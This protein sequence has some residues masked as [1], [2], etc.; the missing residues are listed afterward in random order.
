MSVNGRGIKVF[1]CNSNLEVAKSIAKGIG[2]QLGKCKISTFS[3]GEISISI[4]E[5]VR[6]ADVFI[7]QSTN[8]PVND[9]I[10]ELALMCDACKRSSATSVT[11][12]MPY[13]G[14]ARQDRQTRA[15]EP[16]SAK[17]VANL[18]STSGA[19]RVLTMD[20]HA[21]QIQGFFNIPIDHLLGVPL[22]TPYFKSKLKDNYNDVVIVSPDF[23]SVTRARKFAQSFNAPIAIIDKRRPKANVSEVMNIIGDVKDKTVIIV[24]DMIDT[25]GTLCNAVNAVIDMGGAKEVYACATHGV[26]SGP[27]IE[28]IEKSRIKECVILNTIYQP[29]EKR[30][31][32]ITVLP[33]SA[34]FSEAI[35]R[36]YENKPISTLFAVP[37]VL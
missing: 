7:V 26:L 4:S 12:V 3:D 23:G 11:A 34:V 20:L 37:K 27:A 24:D 25:A 6:G 29:P 2:L 9:N 21:P 33:I 15:R 1:S 19:D 14:Y 16:I 31:D 17:L 5:S 10:M 30:I 18:I 8:A 22:L 36:I 35:D 13:F 28:R 32:K